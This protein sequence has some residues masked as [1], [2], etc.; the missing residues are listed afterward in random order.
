MQRDRIRLRCVSANATARRASAEM[1]ER[2]QVTVA[3]WRLA[4]GTSRRAPGS[5][6]RSDRTRP[7]GSPRGCASGPSA[8][9]TRPPTGLSGS[10]TRTCSPSRRQRA[11]RATGA[12]MTPWIVAMAVGL[13]LAAVAAILWHAPSE[14][15]VARY[16]GAVAGAT[17]LTATPV[18]VAGELRYHECR[19]DAERTSARKVEATLR[20]D[21]VRALRAGELDGPSAADCERVHRAPWSAL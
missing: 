4:E 10:R 7:P 11:V 12:R 17:L 6:T 2:G 18:A 19:D 21:T 3:M 9:A 8:G 1:T 14:R 16:V 5:S 15:R 13:G 20:G